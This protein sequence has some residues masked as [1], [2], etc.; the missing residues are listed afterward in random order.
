L[1]NNERRQCSALWDGPSRGADAASWKLF[2]TPVIRDGRYGKNVQPLYISD[3]KVEE[4]AQRLSP[5]VSPSLSTVKS[6]GEC[7]VIVG[8]RYRNVVSLTLHP[9]LPSELIEHSGVTQLI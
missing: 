5:F 4:E 1:E 6:S 7:I 9:T 2:P 3:L 8:N